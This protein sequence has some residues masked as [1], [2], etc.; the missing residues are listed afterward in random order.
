MKQ[1]GREVMTALCLAL[2][3]I[4]I[5]MPSVLYFKYSP[6][7]SPEDSYA[8]ATVGLN[9]V[10]PSSPPG[11]DD[12]PGGGSGG[13]G[14]GGASYVTHILNFTKSKE[15]LIED[16]GVGDKIIAI[17]EFGV[18]FDFS[19]YFY[20]INEKLVLEISGQKFGLLPDELL[21]FD[22]DENGFDDMVVSFEDNGI[23]FKALDLTPVGDESVPLTRTEKIK[24]PMIFFPSGFEVGF[25]FILVL[26]GL[27][28][29][30][31]FI[32]H[33]IKLRR[34]EKTQSKRLKSMYV[35]YKKKK[36]T[37]EAKKDMTKK[38]NRQKRLLKTAYDS[39]YISLESYHKGLKRINNMMKKI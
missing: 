17:F 36:K 25:W 23:R 2:I 8:T 35:G 16:L 9:V 29:L 13:G 11:D 31:V 14:S 33:Q 34:I 20:K 32:F 15:Y 21:F 12:G 24:Q 39:K 27:A 18:E 3:A 10:A 28:I 26:L 4:S 6:A 37:R 1:I 7:I 38:L 30:L 22:L 5:V 19:V